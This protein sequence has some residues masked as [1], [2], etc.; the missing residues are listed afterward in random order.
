MISPPDSVFSINIIVDFHF[1]QF[2]F[3]LLYATFVGLNYLTCS[4]QV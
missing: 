1:V 3:S 2:G 4:G